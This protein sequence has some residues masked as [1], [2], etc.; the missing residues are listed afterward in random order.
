MNERW[1]ENDHIYDNDTD[2][3]KIEQSKYVYDNTSAI[4]NK[5]EKMEVAATPNTP[6]I[7]VNPPTDNK[8]FIILTYDQIFYIFIIVFIIINILVTLYNGRRS[9]DS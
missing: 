7:Y 2:F 3:Y 6:I 9:R 1:F 4:D 5:K 8:N